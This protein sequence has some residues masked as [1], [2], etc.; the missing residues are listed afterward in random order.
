MLC[1][2][3]APRFLGTAG[4]KSGFALYSSFPICFFPSWLFLWRNRCVSPS[5]EA[6]EWAGSMPCC[7]PLS[8]RCGSSFVAQLLGSPQEVPRDVSPFSHHSLPPSLLVCVSSASTAKGHAGAPS[9]MALLP[10]LQLMCLPA[11]RDIWGC[12]TDPGHRAYLLCLLCCQGLISLAAAAKCVST[13]R[14]ISSALHR[15]FCLPLN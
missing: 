2:S 10:P 3:W 6:G 13:L 15:L 1:V 5:A 11:R 7:P 12:P 4:E 9:L 8:A 14:G